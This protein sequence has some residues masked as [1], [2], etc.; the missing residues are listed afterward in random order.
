MPDGVTVSVLVVPEIST[1][2][3]VDVESVVVIVEATPTD[4]IVIIDAWK[5]SLD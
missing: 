5:S 1:K 3:V 2:G 4:D